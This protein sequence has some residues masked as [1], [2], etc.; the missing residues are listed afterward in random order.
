MFV[1]VFV[2]VVVVGI[3]GKSVVDG[4]KKEKKHN[5][6][7]ETKP[8]ITDPHIMILVQCKETQLNI[9]QLLN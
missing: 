5:K 2:L 4:V 6:Q 9:Y 7:S 8:K 1:F 3:I